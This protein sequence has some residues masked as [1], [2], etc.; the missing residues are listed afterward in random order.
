[1]ICE[2]AQ[3]NRLVLWVAQGFGLG[4]IPIMPGTFGSLLG[5]GWLWLLLCGGRLWIFVLG[6]IFGFALSVWLCG[7]AEKL[8]QKKDPSSVVLDEVTAFPLCYLLWV[9]K[10]WSAH[11]ALPGMNLFF[12][13]QSWYW[14]VGVFVLFRVFDIVKPWPIRASQSLAAGWGVTVDDFLAAFF[15]LALT[16]IFSSLA[17]PF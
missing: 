6:M 13:K 10:F 12:G 3:M 8:L 9:G 2:L 11:H 5:F 17:S 1:M 7:A 4:R 15:V 14:T 16:A